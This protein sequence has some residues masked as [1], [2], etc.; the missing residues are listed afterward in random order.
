[1]KNFYL[2]LL[3]LTAPFLHAQV[4]NETITFEEFGLPVD[5]FLNDAG[6]S[7]GFAQFPLFLPN[8]FNADFNSFS[9]WAISTTTDTVTPDFTNQYSSISGGGADG[10]L[11]Y[12]V[13]FGTIEDSIATSGLNFR[14]VDASVIPLSVSL[15]NSTYAYR[16]MLDG[17]RFAKAFGG[18]TGD[19]PD[20]FLLTIHGYWGGQQVADSV[21][22]Y[23]ADYRFEDNDLDYIVRDWTE[24]DLSVFG[25]VDSLSFT[26]RS[27]DIGMFGPNNPTYVLVDNLNYDLRVSTRTAVVE[28]LFTVYPNPTNGLVTVRY[29]QTGTPFVA[30]LYDGL[31]R[32]VYQ[33]S[34]PS[35]TTLSLADLPRGRYVLRLTDGKVQSSR[36]LIRR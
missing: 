4:V 34:V 35:E 6:S 9:G 30:S 26:Y 13:N 12:A 29:E 15:N 36:T 27:S 24:V 7:G 11:T 28:D 20:F 2:F 19:D 14:I 23:L 1:M 32:R 25:D 8:A 22:F 17:N 5:T 21:D 33:G 18:V 10:S 3:L 31:G 16:T